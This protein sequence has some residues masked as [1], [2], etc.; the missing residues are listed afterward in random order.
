[1]T[2]YLTILTMAPKRSAQ[3]KEIF[4]ACRIYFVKPS[5]VNYSLSIAFRLK[6]KWD[7]EVVMKKGNLEGRSVIQKR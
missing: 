2:E 4:S 6:G 5:L 3:I 7:R 1:M